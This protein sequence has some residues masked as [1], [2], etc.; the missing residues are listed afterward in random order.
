MKRNAAAGNVGHIAPIGLA[1]TGL[2]PTGTGYAAKVPNRGPKRL[3]SAWLAAVL[4]SSGL[5]VGGLTAAGSTAA[6]AGAAGLGAVNTAAQLLHASLSA[7]Q[8]EAGVDWVGTTHTSNVA[9]TLTTKAGKHDGTQSINFHLGSKAGQ[10]SIILVGTTVYIRG[11]AFGLQEYMGF[12]ATAG[13]KEAGRW[14]S[15]EEPDATLVTIYEAVAAG[16]TV[17]S[18]VSELEM[19][20]PLTPTAARTVAGQRVVGVRGTTL[21]NSE[22]PS[23][24]Q[25]LYLKS[26][27]EHLPVEAVQN[28]KDETSSEVLGP[29]GQAP[30][31][32]APGGSVPLQLGWLSS[33]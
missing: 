6:P 30:S 14:V 18:T 5:V 4:A 26:T 31:V 21:V 15:I 33:R 9:V 27:G 10:I 25:V 13:Q 8:G 17:S 29:W 7:A 19:T 2:A 28:L 20:G 22:A 32:Q 11:N 16:L 1:P 3:V 24:P 12:S 23:T